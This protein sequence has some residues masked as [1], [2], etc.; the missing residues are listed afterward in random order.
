LMYIFMSVL[1]SSAPDVFGF[2]RLP[3]NASHG[4]GGHL[5]SKNIQRM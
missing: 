4:N 5:G 3:Q 1:I 2:Q